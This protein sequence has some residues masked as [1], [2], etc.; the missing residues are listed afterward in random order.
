MTTSPTASSEENR[1]SSIPDDTLMAE[2]PLF[3]PEGTTSAF[4]EKLV[5][6]NPTGISNLNNTAYRWAAE[7]YL[8]L[9][10]NFWLP[11]E[12][13]MN[14]DVTDKAKLTS[15]EITAVKDTLSFLIAL[16]NYQVSNL[17]SITGFITSGIVRDVL[18]E[19]SAQEVVHNHSYQYILEKLFNKDEGDEI[20]TR[21]TTNPHLLKRIEY[22]A[23]IGNSFRAFPTFK[24]FKRVLI[25]NLVLEGLYFFTGFNL[26]DQLNDRHLLPGTSTQIDYIRKD[27]ITHLVTFV[28]IINEIFTAKDKQ[29]GIAMIREAG[30]QEL[31][32]VLETYGNNISGINKT[33]STQYVHFLVNQL[34]SFLQLDPIYPDRGNPY[35]NL[36]TGNVKKNFFETKPHEYL[37]NLDWEG[38]NDDEI[39]LPLDSLG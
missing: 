2:S 12:V 18:T 19:Q 23:E 30:Q 35:H 1:Y 36:D 26:F 8:I 31:D 13:G 15:Y 38:W 21:Y 25:G 16:D 37:L 6:G 32:W 28:H 22:L 3:N 14:Q 24:N 11:Q 4:Y 20:Y 27:E 17:P 29:D 33:S 9:K 5:F 39:T 34:L 7:H 10:G